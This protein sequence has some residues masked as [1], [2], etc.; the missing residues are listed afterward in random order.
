[1]SASCWS[2]TRRAPTARTRSASSSSRDRSRR[3][4]KSCPAPASASRNRAAPTG[5]AGPRDR[6][7]RGRWSRPDRGP[8]GD[9]AGECKKGRLDSRP[10]YVA[11][12]AASALAEQFV[13]LSLQL[14]LLD[15]ASA[16][17]LSE[18]GDRLG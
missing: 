12:F 8:T 13:D 17:P 16:Q 4:R 18:I 7:Q 3:S 2:R 5:A 15:L 1:M 6:P 9:A 14:T 10:F 11:R